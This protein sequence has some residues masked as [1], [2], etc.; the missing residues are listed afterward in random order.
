MISQV[1]VQTPAVL[2]T[3]ANSFD[4]PSTARNKPRFYLYRA[5]NIKGKCD[6]SMDVGH[7]QRKCAIGSTVTC[8]SIQD[9]RSMS[10]RARGAVMGVWLEAR[11]AKEQWRSTT[12]P[13]QRGLYA[14]DASWS[15]TALRITRNSIGRSTGG[16]VSNLQLIKVAHDPCTATLRDEFAYSLFVVI[17]GGYDRG[18]SGRCFTFSRW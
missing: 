6:T 10:A 5:P 12:R 13:S 17:S 16:Y 1:D 8:A 11:V 4:F 18:R 7:A 15:N 14:V 9:R 3:A 2:T